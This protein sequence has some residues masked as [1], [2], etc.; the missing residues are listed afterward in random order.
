MWDTNL[1]AKFEVVTVLVRG[2][3]GT[4]GRYF[5]NNNASAKGVLS[6]DNPGELTVILDHTGW[7]KKLQG[8]VHNPS[9][10]RGGYE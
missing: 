6:F 3:F 8:G 5:H 4:M 7:A 2:F 10:G 1:E 9:G